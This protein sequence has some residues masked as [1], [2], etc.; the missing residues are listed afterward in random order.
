MRSR[1]IS[2]R[3]DVAHVHPLSRM[4]LISGGNPKFRKGLPV[5]MRAISGHS[6][7]GFTSCPGAGL[8]GQLGT[9]RRTSTLGLPK[10]YAP[11]VEGSLEVL[12][13]SRLGCR[14]RC[15]GA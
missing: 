11:V 10:L 12:S 13:A 5:W 7:T 3:L 8:Y 6:D 15:R 4:S 9:I 1:L 14:P 2:W